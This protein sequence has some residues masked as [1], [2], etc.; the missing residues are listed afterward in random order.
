MW[1]YSLGSSCGVHMQVSHEYQN[2][3][4]S[5]RHSFAFVLLNLMIL[6]LF[7][8]YSAVVP[9]LWGGSMWYPCHF[10]RMSWV[11]PHLVILC[12]FRSCELLQN[13]H[14]LYRL[15]SLRKSKNYTNI[16]LGNTNL[17]IIF[18]FFHLENNSSRLTPGACELRKLGLLARATIL[19]VFFSL[20]R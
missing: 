10:C 11:P 3:I 20:M 1:Q 9:K 7:M 17:E 8:P 19:G 15:N 4:M 12:I 16:Q 18:I 2:P 13:H 6:Y 5:R 14:L